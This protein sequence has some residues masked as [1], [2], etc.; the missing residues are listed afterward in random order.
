MSDDSVAY[1]AM[2]EMVARAVEAFSDVDYQGREWVRGESRPAR[3]DNFTT[4]LNALDD[5]QMLEAP[6][7]TI[8]DILRDER[9][10]AVFGPL[11]DAFENL[12]GKLGTKLSDEEYLN[13]AE[14]PQVVAAA[15]AALAVLS[16]TR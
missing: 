14:W 13:S 4:Q 9:E 5:V 2:R 11:S 1:P 10:V 7:N 16:E 12:F 6:E 3:L 8:G 15:K